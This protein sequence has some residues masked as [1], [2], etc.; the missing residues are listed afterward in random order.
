MPGWQALFDSFN[1]LPLIAILTWIGWRMKREA[2]CL[3]GLSMALHCAAD[4]PLHAHDGH[5]HFFPLSDWRFD[6]PVS[7]WDP[8]HFGHIVAPIEFV[9][10]VGGCVLLIA[11]GAQWRWLG[12]AIL[13]AD[14]AFGEYASSVWGG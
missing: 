4:L 11:R 8:R 14:F 13:A 10:V 5:R 1:S 3:V 9:F 12:G 2:L 7:Y 6:S